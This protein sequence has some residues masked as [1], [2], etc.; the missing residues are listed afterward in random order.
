MQILK[1]S[2]ILNMRKQ[3]GWKQKERKRYTVQTVPQERCI[4][5]LISDEREFKK[6]RIITDKMDYF[7]AEEKWSFSSFPPALLRHI[8][9]C[10][11]STLLFCH[12]LLELHSRGDG[13]SSLIGKIK[14]LH[15]QK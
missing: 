2:C 6:K 7:T 10:V 9:H 11:I 12:R 3:T 4:A 8:S 1:K 14:T 13:E 5:I 15:C